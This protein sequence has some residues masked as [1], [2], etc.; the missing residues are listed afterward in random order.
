M[1]GSRAGYNPPY[2]MAPPPGSRLGPDEIVALIGA[3]PNLTANYDIGTRDD[4]TDVVHELLEGETLRSV[5]PLVLALTLAASG[6]TEV[7]GTGA[8]RYRNGRWFDGEGFARRDAYVVGD[9]FIAAAPVK[10]D[11]VVDLT[12]GFVVPAFG[13]AH[14]HNVE[15]AATLD[16]VVDG[17]LRAGVFYAKVPG[18]IAELSA[19]IRDRVNHPGSID[20]VFSNAAFTSRGGHPVPLYRG[21]LAKARYEPVL[22]PLKP[23]WFD[24]RA[25]FQVETEEELDAAWDRLMATDPDFVKVHLLGGST[26]AAHPGA[27]STSG[28]SADAS[29]AGAATGDRRGLNRSLLPKVV[30]RASAAGLRVTAHVETA[31]DFRTAVAAG[32]SEIAHVPGHYIAAAEAMGACLLTAEDAREAARRDVTV[33]TTTYLARTSP[34]PGN[35]LELADSALAANLRTLRDNG[36]RLA[37]GSDHGATSLPEVDNLR[38]L[39]VFDPLTLL[40][41]WAEVTPRAVFPDRLVGRLA[42]GYEA[43]FLSLACNPVEDF[44]CVERIQLRVK[45]GRLLPPLPEPAGSPTPLAHSPH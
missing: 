22:G 36:V 45:Q 5:L 29:H 37:I 19:E 21:H 6:C 18:G 30:E 42:E 10:I 15:L 17:Y 40:R 9:R 26:P 43:N 28:E 7:E 4:A 3:H 44:S 13:E 25:Y 2:F 14:N 8:T 41:N 38:R 23:E 12:G 35:N 31:D 11:S 33:V 1:G 20:V 39:G 34:W 32:V 16:D 27:T 24:G